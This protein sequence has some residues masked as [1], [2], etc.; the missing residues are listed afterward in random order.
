MG[1]RD[2]KRQVQL[3]KYNFTLLAKASECLLL[4]LGAFYLLE[5]CGQCLTP[6]LSSHML[7][8]RVQGGMSDN[9]RFQ[10]LLA[11]NLLGNGNNCSLDQRLLLHRK[12]TFD[13]WHMCIVS[14]WKP[15]GKFA[16]PYVWGKKNYGLKTCNKFCA[17]RFMRNP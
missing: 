1:V 8:H 7:A 11:E 9:W 12:P 4:F 16:N 2:G 14:Q 5:A 15:P 10:Q 17:E 13:M 3:L 6:I